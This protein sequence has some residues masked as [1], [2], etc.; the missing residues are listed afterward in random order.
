M[1]QKFMVRT[2]SG[3]SKAVS[4]EDAL[5]MVKAFADRGVEAF[6]VSEDEGK[7]IK[8]LNNQ[9]NPPSWS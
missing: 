1:E 2:E 8:A 9:F 6:I 3:L 7:R 5:T 4:R